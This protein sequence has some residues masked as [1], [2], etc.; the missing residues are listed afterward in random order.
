MTDTKPLDTDPTS[1]SYLTTGPLGPIDAPQNL[2]MYVLVLDSIREGVSLSDE[3]GTICYTNPAEDSLFGYERGELVG[4]HVSVQNAYPPEENERVVRSIME[5]LKTNGHWSGEFSNRR[6]DGSVFTTFAR[7]TEIKVD[8]RH[9][10][11]CVQEDITDR[12]RIEDVLA[13]RVR[14]QAA[15]AELGVRALS[16]VDLGTLMNEVVNTVT[17]TL[18]VELC[19]VLEVLPGGEELLLR[20][21]AGWREGLVGHHHL[22]S[23]TQSLAGYTLAAHEPIIVYDLRAEGRFQGPQLL[24]DHNVVSGMSVI[25]HGSEGPFGVLGAHSTRRRTFTIDDVNFLQSVANVLAIAIERTRVEEKLHESRDQLE[26]ILQGVAD[27]I[28]VQDK[29]GLLTYANDAALQAIGFSSREE[30]LQAPNAGV[31]NKF[32]MLDEELNPF[33]PEDLPGRQ[34]LKGADMAE[35]IVGWRY[36]QTGEFHWSVVKAAPIK[37]ERGE[38]V[39]AVSIFRDITERM[40]LDRRK[41]EF[42]ALASHELKTPITS[43]KIFAQ[44][45]K[46]R[47]ERAEDSAL[48]QDAIRHLSRMD[49]QL[50][51][52]TELVRDLLD[53]SKL[54]A[55]KLSYNMEDVDLNDLVR[56]T[57][58][59]LQRV[60][61]KHT[62]EV[63]GEAPTNV[64]MDRDRIKQVLSNLLSNAIKY[65]PQADRIL[66]GIDSD[67][68]PEHGEIVVFVKDF[69]IGVEP[70]EQE[71]IFDRFFQVG[72]P[73]NLG[74]ETFP[75]LGLGL[76]ISSEIVRRHGGKIWVDSEPGE[77]ST[78]SFSLPTTPGSA[79]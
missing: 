66:A 13:I 12:R 79:D 32:D 17:R 21:G 41:D 76:Y 46:R 3:R 52:L 34:V 19:K 39:L 71:R 2:R 45:L 72:G 33:S 6:K 26:V 43:L 22:G 16:G 38:V 29:N 8:G 64:F 7:I 31:L 77:G 37:N 30:F 11:V 55:G 14:Q 57:V 24:T 69:G 35:R 5:H 10:W 60:A 73:V 62:I 9:Y 67:T 18:D 70:Q 65:S 56:E 28:T 40:E 47:F 51:K 25:I 48:G 68:E 50:N 74:Q 1:N 59:D 23:G 44:T 27:G 54:R 4:K 75:G 36:R 42:L 63:V 15:V 20:A 58:E 61:D 53:V 49:D 78:F